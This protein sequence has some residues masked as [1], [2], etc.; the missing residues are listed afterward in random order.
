MLHGTYGNFVSYPR[1]QNGER[2]WLSDR[3]FPTY[4]G[5]RERLRKLDPLLTHLSLLSVNCRYDFLFQDSYFRLRIQA[6]PPIY[7]HL[8]FAILQFEISSLMNW[9]FSLF[10]TW[11]L[12]ATAG[13]KIQFK[14]GKK[15]S[16]SN[17]IFQ[18]GKL[19]KSSGDK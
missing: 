9:I 7:L 12:Q 19:Q 2:L 8:I 6:L 4:W 14:L 17:L 16:S 5:S 13:R 15:S 18:A 1:P 11:I 10:Q 3:E